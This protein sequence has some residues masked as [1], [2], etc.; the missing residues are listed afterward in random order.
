LSTEFAF[1]YYSLFVWKKEDESDQYRYT[2]YKDNSSL[3]F[4]GFVI[5]IILTETV[6]F[7]FLFIK[8]NLIFAWIVFTLSLY[9]ALQLFAHAKAMYLRS[10]EIAR[11]LVIRYGLMGDVIID[12]NQIQKVIY[13]S[14]YKSCEED[15]VVKL[16]FLKTLESYSVAIEFNQF[17]SIESFYGIKK[18]AKVL[19]L[20]VD[21][22]REFVKQLEKYIVR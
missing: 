18:K 10:T 5:F 8:I 21:N 7:H 20:P 19:L 15:V 14:N 16:G 22:G 13:T 1:I 4:Y 2:C 17:V 12:Y 3:V 6:V 9:F 11:S